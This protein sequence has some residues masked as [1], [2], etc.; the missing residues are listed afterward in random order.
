MELSSA[1]YTH[2]QLLKA[3]VGAQTAVWEAFFH[4]LHYNPDVPESKDCYDITVK[5]SDRRLG[6]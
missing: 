3:G 1:L 4:G 5:Y 2:L 6:E